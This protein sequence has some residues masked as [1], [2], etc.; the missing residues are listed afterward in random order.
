MRAALSAVCSLIDVMDPSYIYVRIYQ[1]Q[2]NNSQYR[3]LICIAPR[4]P[5]L[6]VEVVVREHVVCQGVYDCTTQFVEVQ[7]VPA[8]TMHERFYTFITHIHS[9]FLLYTRTFQVFIEKHKTVVVMRKHVCS[10]V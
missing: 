2:V 6:L 9:K 10:E 1:C 5:R 3:N 8:N 7:T 4:P